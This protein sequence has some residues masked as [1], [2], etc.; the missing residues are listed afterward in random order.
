MKINTFHFEDKLNIYELMPHEYFLGHLIV[1]YPE[2]LF[3]EKLNI[4]INEINYFTYERDWKSYPQVRYWKNMW[5]SNIEKIITSHPQFNKKKM[6]RLEQMYRF[7]PRIKKQVKSKGQIYSLEHEELKK[8]SSNDELI[9]TY[10]KLYL[11]TNKNE[12]KQGVMFA[13]YPH[14]NNSFGAFDNF[15]I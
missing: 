10:E 3:D 4:K 2:E 6:N 8:C 14:Y 15:P 11:N 9:A 13:T 5:K 1:K 7:P 12:N